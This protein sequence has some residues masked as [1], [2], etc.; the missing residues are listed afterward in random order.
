MFD[1]FF[2]IYTILSAILIVITLAIFIIKCI[3]GD[4][5]IRSTTYAS[6]L[7]YLENY[8]LQ[9]LVKRI[10]RQ[11]NQD[12]NLRL[13]FKVILTESLSEY[14]EENKIT[15]ADWITRSYQRAFDEHNME[16]AVILKRDG[17][18]NA[19]DITFRSLKT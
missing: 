12:N 18:P 15:V 9:G 10:V 13:L 4:F 6:G 14:T 11:G 8:I 3:D 7:S 5:V 17:H 16:V 1:V 19:L 2:T